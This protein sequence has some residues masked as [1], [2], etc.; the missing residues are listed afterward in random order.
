MA[1]KGIP[2]EKLIKHGWCFFNEYL[3]D[4]EIWSRRKDI[5]L[6]HAES[7]IVY[8]RYSV[9]KRIEWERC[10][11]KNLHHLCPRSRGGSS[12]ES[13]LLLIDKSKHNAWHLLFGTLTLDEIISLLQKVKELKHYSG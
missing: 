1:T 10:G 3:L 9:K 7:G 2:K 11:E 8:Y 4:L 6:Y 5:L 12:L 13:N